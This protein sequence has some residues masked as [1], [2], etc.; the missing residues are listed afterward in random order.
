MLGIW[1]YTVF[2]FRTY[3]RLRHVTP[4][5]TLLFVLYMLLVGVLV[6]NVYFAWQVHQKLPPLLQQFPAVTF[7]KGRL[8][9]PDRAVSVS[10]PGTPYRLVLDA[11]GTVPT[12]QQFLAQKILAFVAGDKI[13]MPSVSGVNAQPIPPQVDGEIS[14]RTLQ[15]YLPTLRSL[16]LSV[17]FFSSFVVVGIFLAF[18]Y[19]LALAVVFFWRGLTRSTV[20]PGVLRRWAAFLQGPALVLWIFHLLIGVPLFLFGLFIL[21][22][23]YTQQIFNTLPRRGNHAA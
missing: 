1:L 16:L 23:I 2:G 7:E 10:V 14:S 20:P 6:F 13:Y 3:H 8:T 15:S 11:Q 17:L 5:R 12:Q 19:F 9:A 21:F 4:G 22:M 18:S